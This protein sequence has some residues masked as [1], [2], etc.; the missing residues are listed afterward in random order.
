[1][2][3]QTH[4]IDASAT[5]SRIAAFVLIVGLGVLALTAQSQSRSGSM[6]TPSTDAVAEFGD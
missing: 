3:T 5:R 1:M 4:K 6:Q 2:T